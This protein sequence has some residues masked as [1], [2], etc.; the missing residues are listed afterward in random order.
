M[1]PLV[2]FNQGIV[3]IP[4]LY[5]SILSTSSEPFPKHILKFIALILIMNLFF[6]IFHYTCHVNKF[7]YR[8]IHYLHHTLIYSDGMGALYT[9][10]LEQIFVNLLPIVLSILIVQPNLFLAHFF[11]AFVSWGTVQSHNNYKK[12]TKKS[13]I[14]H[15]R[16]LIYNYDNPPNLFDRVKGSYKT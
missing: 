2:L 10:P 8:H 5:D 4:C 15:H 6:S 3:L 7:L 13:H 1:L 16:Y 11:V 14:S 9:H 12:N